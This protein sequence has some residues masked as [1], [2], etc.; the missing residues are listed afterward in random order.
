VGLQTIF[1]IFL[2]L[3]ITA[4]AGVGLYTFYPSP[5]RAINQRMTALNRQE[6]AIRNARPPDELTVEDRQRIQQI[7]DELARMEDARSVDREAWGRR[8]SIALIALATLSMILSIARGVQLPA[9]SN[10]LLLGGVF[11]MVYGVGWIIVTDGSAAR[12]FVMAVALA[13]TLGLGYL[14]FVRAPAA[15]RVTAAVTAPAD[16]RDLERR[17]EALEAR[18]AGAARALG[19]STHDREGSSNR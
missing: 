14:R 13:I 12:F 4:F 6:L 15:G 18:M 19:P 5:D 10:G 17:V 3:M 7:Q 1:A 2:G 8:T 11:T 9:I 16:V